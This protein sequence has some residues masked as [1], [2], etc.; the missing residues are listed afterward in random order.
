MACTV[1]ARSDVLSR[2]LGFPVP[3]LKRP[4]N[5]GLRRW[6]PAATD[7]RFEAEGIG[8]RVAAVCETRPEVGTMNVLAQ[9]IRYAFRLLAKHRA[10][11]AAAI[12][13]LALGIGANTAI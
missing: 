2:A 12:L 3:G 10:L 5:E 11:T 7:S 8:T 4:R 13:S 6:H 9:D 1:R